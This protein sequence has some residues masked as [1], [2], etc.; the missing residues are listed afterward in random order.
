MYRF[1]DSPWFSSGY[2]FLPDPLLTLFFHFILVTWEIL[3]LNSVPPTQLSAMSKCHHGTCQCCLSW[4]FLFSLGLIAEFCWLTFLPLSPAFLQGVYFCWPPSHQALLPFVGL[5]FCF[6]TG[7]FWCLHSFTA[8][9]EAGVAFGSPYVYFES[10][11]YLC[12]PSPSLL[13]IDLFSFL[14]FLE[15]LQKWKKKVATLDSR[16]PLS[17]SMRA[18]VT[19]L[20]VNLL[21]SAGIQCLSWKLVSSS[22]PRKFQ[23]VSLCELSFLIF[24]SVS[25]R[26][27]SVLVHCL[28]L[29]SPPIFKYFVHIF[30][31]W[32]LSRPHLETSRSF[33]KGLR[34]T[35][36]F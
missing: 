20:F 2:H 19:G 33:Q 10:V 14:L 7:A 24:S 35:I 23:D 13:E 21:Y 9:V 17:P 15:A 18:S 29:H 31:Y 26:K 27:Y 6:P 22:N 8:S 11:D 1:H 36:L 25:F 12:L 4:V 5:A 30:L 34:V 16:L 28:H 3:V 32:D